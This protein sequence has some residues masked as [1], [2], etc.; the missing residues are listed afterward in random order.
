MQYL[1]AAIVIIALLCWHAFLQWVK[2]ARERE[3]RGREAFETEVRKGYAEFN[4]LWTRDARN[5]E[6]AIKQ[7]RQADGDIAKLCDS[8]IEA[9]R[10]AQ[11]A[12][13]GLTDR[14]DALHARVEVQEQALKNAINEL[15]GLIGPLR[16]EILNA[17]TRERRV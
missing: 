14:I 9:L 17:K 6:D 10:D 12:P 11:D 5:F 13:K 2:L 4:Q 1:S 8:R 7:L 15:R 16:Q 3:Q